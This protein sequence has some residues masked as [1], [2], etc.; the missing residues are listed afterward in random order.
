MKVYLILILTVTLL[1]SVAISNAKEGA[2]RKST[3][4]LLELSLE[5][6]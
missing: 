4:S 1:G 3:P 2:T 5:Q 6:P